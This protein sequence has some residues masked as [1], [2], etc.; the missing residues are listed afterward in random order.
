M[1]PESEPPA[2]AEAESSDNSDAEA[3][4]AEQE[5]ATGEAVP[6]ET[7]P[8][9]P[10]RLLPALIGLPIVAGLVASAILLVDYLRPI[11]V[12]CESGGGC[13][14]IKHTNEA[15]QFI[16][17]TPMLGLIGFFAIGLVALMRGKTG[18][19]LFAMGAS[20]GGLFAGHLISVQIG[21]GVFCKYCMVADISAIVLMVAATVRS[22]RKW[23]PP[24]SWRVR[25]FAASG[26][27]AAA[28]IPIVIGKSLKVPVPDAIKTEMASTEAGKVTV[29]DFVDYECPFCRRTNVAF[30]PILSAN[31]SRV[32]VVRRN[33]PL[34]MHPH[35]MDA[36]KAACCGAKLG[37]GEEMTHA[38][39][40]TDVENLTPEGCA[41]VASKLGLQPD[42]FSACVQDPT[43]EASIK[44]D[45]DEFHAAKGEGLPTIWVDDEPLMGEQT[46]DM[47][48]HAMDT[49]MKKKGST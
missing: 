38:L 18:R 42:A 24:Q 23:D 31:A 14:A 12:Y 2:E 36:A 34:E 25:V 1:A 44:A 37:K 26:L 21:Y 29:V 22:L 32:R 8:E 47:L 30:E 9:V 46:T 19:L 15:W 40:S 6:P 17:P 41:A 16:L 45:I 10:S 11:P 3:S 13:D 27:I 49:A 35:A 7:A 33:V 4:L 5:P 43:T 28:A 39:L 48:E 20:L